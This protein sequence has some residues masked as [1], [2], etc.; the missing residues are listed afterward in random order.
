MGPVEATIT[1][2]DVK[3]FAG[4]RD[5]P[6][7]MDLDGFVTTV[8]TGTLSFDSNN[9]SFAGQNITSVVIEMPFDAVKGGAGDVVNIWSTASRIGE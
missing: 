9:D 8:T 3:V 6:F 2:G 7:F 5:D 1:D 4:L